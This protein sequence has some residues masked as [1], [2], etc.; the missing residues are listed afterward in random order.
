MATLV[1][2]KKN[3]VVSAQHTRESGRRGRITSEINAGANNRGDF[4]N[5]KE[6]GNYKGKG[7]LKQQ[8]IGKRQDRYRDLVAAFGRVTNEGPGNGSAKVSFS[9]G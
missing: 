2:S 9:A 1:S 7:T 8:N 6:M 4:A 3:K 5:S